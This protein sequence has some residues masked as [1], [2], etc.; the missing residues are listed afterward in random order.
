MDIQREIWKVRHG[1]T[2]NVAGKLSL[3][4]GMPVIIRN[5]DATELC[6]TNGQEG[7]VSG[8]QSS[9]AG[10]G[11]R[12]P[13]TLFI[14]LNNPPKL[15]QIPGLPD[16]VVPIVR[17]TKT[18]QCV[19]PSDHKES[20]ER[21]QVS[22]LPNFAMTTHAA[23]GKTRPYN[24]VHLNSC[25]NH[26]SYYSSLS[27]SASAAG[28][29]I[30][31]GFDSKVITR[32]CSGYL[33]QE[34]REQ[35]LLD[36]ITKLRYTGKLPTHIE[37][38]TRTAMIQEFQLWIG[39]D[40]LPSKTD[41]TLRWLTQDPIGLISSV[42]DSPWQLVDKT[43]SYGNLTS[44]GN[45]FVSAKGSTSVIHNNLKHQQEAMITDAESPAKKA[46]NSKA[47]SVM[48]SPLGLT[49]DRENYSCGYDSLLVI[50]F[51]IWKDNPQVWSGVFRGLNRHCALWSQGFDNI[52]KGSTT[53]E[54][55]RDDWRY[56]LHTTDPVM[57]PRGTH[58]IS[59]AGL[60]EEILKV[61]E[62]IASSQHQCS[63]CEYAEN[64][65]DDKLTY[66]LH[67][68]NSTKHST[69]TWVNG[70]SQTTHR[71]CPDCNHSMKQVIFYNEIPNIV[72]LEY[73]MKNIQTSHS[74][75]IMTD[76]GEMTILNLRGLVYHGGYHF[77]SR[78]ISSEEKVWYHDGIN[79]GKLCL[80]DGI[81]GNQ[82]DD[83]L[84]MCRGRDLVLAVYA[85]KF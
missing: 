8:W 7:F 63:T 34:F 40:Y 82:S 39:T 20:I 62:S 23:Q 47:S 29:A 80:T 52:I 43:K 81:L 54:Q 36:E 65:I 33:R 26:M 68:D 18:I 84:R 41:P 74:L 35:E 10:H 25:F 3:C 50:L 4:Q 19:F 14:Q 61:T 79:T 56:V 70:L 46:K 53:F 55:V 58:G 45:A 31:Q 51:D 9:K 77:T 38:G 72:I 64:P 73:P 1:A 5:N 37:P 24:V 16:N 13:D 42:N 75:K 83:R 48:P 44:T 69:N 22:V 59:V 57:F 78:I 67:A 76:K 49:W 12:V 85:Q 15:V 32:G 17:N 60:A 28:T 30:I 66:V 2:D 21:Q 71:R 6:M 11:K 27:R